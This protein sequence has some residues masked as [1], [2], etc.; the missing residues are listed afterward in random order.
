MMAQ[1]RSEKECCERRMSHIKHCKP[2][3]TPKGR[4]VKWIEGPAFSPS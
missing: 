1:A 3:I 2:V 4:R